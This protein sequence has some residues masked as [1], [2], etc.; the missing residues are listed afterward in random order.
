MKLNY[1]VDDINEDLQWWNYDLNH[2]DIVHDAA[3]I[4]QLN[5]NSLFQTCLSE[6]LTD[7]IYT[8]AVKMH[9]TEDATYFNPIKI[10][11]ASKKPPVQLQ[12]VKYTIHDTYSGKKIGILDKITPSYYF[13]PASRSYN[14]EVARNLNTFL[15]ANSL[16]NT[17][18]PVEVDL[19]KYGFT[20][21]TITM[22]YE[23]KKCNYLIVNVKTTDDNFNIKITPNKGEYEPEYPQ[24]P[25]LGG[26]EVKAKFFRENAEKFED[27]EF[28][29]HGKRFILCKL[30]GDLMHAVYK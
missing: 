22:S 5:A 13:D 9:N 3:N 12:N 10:P 27:R 28:V 8:D 11:K 6:I 14:A 19:T 20:E 15:N 2:E 23:F 1:Q 26:N 4:K 7:G 25:Y 17:K 29:K 24:F 16:L 18:T 30:L 21:T